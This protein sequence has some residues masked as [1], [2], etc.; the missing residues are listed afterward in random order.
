MAT[1]M[2]LSALAPL[3]YGV[4]QIAPANH[5]A[6]V[7]HQHGEEAKLG[8]RQMNGLAAAKHFERCGAKG[9]VSHL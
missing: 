4:H 7:G 5:V 3:H 8:G 6:S 1:S 9:Q 2:L